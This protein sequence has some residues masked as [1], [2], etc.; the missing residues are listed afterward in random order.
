MLLAVR[1]MCRVL[2]GMCLFICVLGVFNFVSMVIL[3]GVVWI[4]AQLG[5]GVIV[6]IVFGLGMFVLGLV[7]FGLAGEISFVVSGRVIQ[8]FFG[9][10]PKCKAHPST[11][12]PAAFDWPDQI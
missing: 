4:L 5:G 1:A 6:L 11:C 7:S 10:A 8:R 2:L 12:G 3:S 9:P